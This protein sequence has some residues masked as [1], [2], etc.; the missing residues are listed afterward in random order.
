MG[1]AVAGV[2]ASFSG[3]AFA[4]PPTRGG[5]GPADAAPA[6]SV[7]KQQVLAAM[8]R[9]TAFMTDKVSVNGGYV[10]SYLPDLSRRWGEMEAY[11]TM[12]W[13]QDPGTPAMGEL[14]IDAYHATGDEQYYKA[15]MQTAGAL[16]SGQHPAG[17]WGY[18]IN[19]AGEESTKKW[20]ATI[21]KN[22]W[23]LEEFQHYYG[24]ATFDDEVTYDAARFML[25][26]YLE[27]K[28]AKVKASLDKTIQFVVDSQYPNGGWPQRYPPTPPELAF[29][30]DGLPDY[31]G[32]I[33]FNDGVCANNVEFLIKCYS[34]LGRKE[35]LDPI[36]RGM[37][38]FVKTQGKAPQAGWGLQHDP[39]TLEPASARTYEP[40]GFVTHTTGQNIGDMIS[41]YYLTGDKKFLA[42]LP[43]AF[44]WLDASRVGQDVQG[45][46]GTHPTFLEV[47]TNKPLYIHRSGSNATNGHYFADGNPQNLIGHYSSFRTVNTDALRARYKE[48]LDTPPEI[49]TKDSPIKPG[50]PPDQIPR[51]EG[52]GARGGG[53][54]G[55][56]A[57]NPADRAAQLVASLN[58]QGYWLTAIGSISNPYKA[59]GPKEVTPGDFVRTNV[60]DEF[61]TSPYRPAQPVMGIT[62]SSYIGNMEALIRYLE[63]AK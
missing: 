27:K 1:L 37:D 43:E 30:K 49:A 5:A 6:V 31:T 46:R 8:K 29:K 38:I 21:G 53:R 24:N 59:D 45:A 42:R 41:F 56:G 58:A 15:A 57:A 23:R 20:F 55:R 52:S 33:T 19:A 11:P 44:D 25:R 60:G 14:F 48:A 54:G 32:F 10:W 36:N 18:F 2:A 61:D 7:D 39:V 47:G 4:A 22:G 13:I 9:A 12:S 17:G 40:K 62:S 16:I 51:I 35:L 50:G 63:T 26:L 3:S 34:L 28:D